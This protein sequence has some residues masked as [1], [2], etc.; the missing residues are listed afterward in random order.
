M[1]CFCLLFMLVKGDAASTTKSAIAPG[2]ID[3]HEYLNQERSA[4]GRDTEK[5]EAIV[6]NIKYMVS[7]ADGKVGQFYI[8]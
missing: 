8:P 6:N 5:L 3:V 7:L 1:D 4:L 2:S